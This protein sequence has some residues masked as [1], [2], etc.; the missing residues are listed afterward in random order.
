MLNRSLVCKASF[1]A[2]IGVLVCGASPAGAT[3]PLSN[4]K[5]IIIM[6]QENRSFDNYFGALPYAKGTPYHASKAPKGSTV[7]ICK[8]TDTKCLDG[9][10]CTKATK[11]KPMACSNSNP[12]PNGNPVTS[13]HQTNYCAGP[14]FDHSWIGSHKMINFSNP[15]DTLTSTPMDGFIRDNALTELPNQGMAP[16]DTMGFFNETDLPFYYFLAENFAVNDRFFGGALAE[17]FPNHSYELAAT[18]FGHLSTSEI[19]EDF[20]HPPGPYQPITL[21]IF[22]LLNDNNVSWADYYTDIAY[23]GLFAPFT[24]HQKP[25]SN[26]ATDVGSDDTLPAVA[27]MSG[28]VNQTDEH[29]PADIQAGEYYISQNLTALRNSPTWNDSIVFILWDE[30]GGFYD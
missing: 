1:G 7:P 26:F 28:A 17:T 29:P 4:V 10:T 16:W 22:D 27:L 6:M 18:S 21:S 2:F 25:I 12:D 8:S 14:D 15:D 13:F 9:L 11:K 24:A 19:T 20:L 23:S 3:G 30:F 5:H